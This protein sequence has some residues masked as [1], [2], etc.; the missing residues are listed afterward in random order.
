[1]KVGASKRYAAAT[2]FM[3]AVTTLLPSAALAAK[4]KAKKKTEKVVETSAPMPEPVAIPA[5]AA[6]AAEPPPSKKKASAAQLET[7]LEPVP[8]MKSAEQLYQNAEFAQSI[9]VLDKLLRTDI[10]PATRKQARLYMALNFL[11]LGN[12]ARAR[13]AFQ[14]LL[15]LDPEFTLPTFSSPSVRA[16]FQTVKT[17]YK[18][19]PTIEHVPP[20]S[21][22][23]KVGADL[24]VSLGRMRKGYQ[25]KL[26]FRAQGTP[27]FSNIDLSPAGAGDKY[28]ATIP[29]A[30]LVKPEGYTLEYFIV[31]TEGADLPLVQLRD[32]QSPFSVPVDVP[33]VL[34]SKPVHKRWYFWVALGGAVLV[35]GGVATAVVLTR[36][37]AQPYGDANVVLRF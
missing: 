3:L 12:E 36:P 7:V 4:K 22:D 26:Y 24:S 17:T 20:K 29:P 9:L 30:M 19:I 27:Y 23:A 37:Q 6:P 2:A 11:A 5:P 21:I 16:F 18:I 8:S 14:D 15:D 1:M 28:A 13:S 10:D 35:A 32:P 34:E 31:V 25:P 33:V